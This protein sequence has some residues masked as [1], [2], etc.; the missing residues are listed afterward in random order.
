VSE[1]FEHDSLSR[2]WDGTGLHDNMEPPFSVSRLLGW[3]FGVGRTLTSSTNGRANDSNP[4][5]RLDCHTR[6]TGLKR[7][8]WMMV[9]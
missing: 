8:C 1:F 7:I 3:E 2:H 5:T 9:R 6:P 4:T